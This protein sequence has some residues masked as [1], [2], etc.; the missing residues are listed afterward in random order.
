M[1]VSVPTSDEFQAALSGLQDQLDTLNEV[2]SDLDAR[3]AALEAGTD[4]TPPDPPNPPVTMGR[5][6]TITIGGQQHVFQQEGATDL[7]D[8]IGHYF[9]Q[10]CYCA[11]N[12]DLP[13][14]R[15][16]FRPDSGVVA[17]A[18]GGFELGEIWPAQPQA[19][20]GGYTATITKDGV[21][22]A[23]IS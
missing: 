13:G 10:H 20:L 8:Y 11:T 15:V 6:A 21:E 19:N 17:R 1:P 23:T 18:G 4:P 2:V 7:G 5:C 9:T 14:F 22:L 3:V 16:F 12:P